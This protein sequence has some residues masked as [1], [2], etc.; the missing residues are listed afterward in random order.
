MKHI[1]I[2]ALLLALF[3]SCQKRELVY[4]L[5]APDS[6]ASVA[7]SSFTGVSDGQQIA[8]LFTPAK[9]RNVSYYLIYSSDNKSELCVIGKVESSGKNSSG[10]VTYHFTDTQPKADTTYYMIGY[11]SNDSTSNYFQQMLKVGL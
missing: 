3:C 7:L 4:N 5:P 11:A 8:L 2:S 6:N 9:K 10:P 1:F